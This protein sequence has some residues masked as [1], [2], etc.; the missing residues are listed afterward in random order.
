MLKST[1]E[2]PLLGYCGSCALVNEDSLFVG[3]QLKPVGKVK[4]TQQQLKIA[5]LLVEFEQSSEWEALQNLLRSIID[6]SFIARVDEID[7][8]AIKVQIVH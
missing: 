3:Q 6:A 4:A 1:S 2:D 7:D 5:G 8:V